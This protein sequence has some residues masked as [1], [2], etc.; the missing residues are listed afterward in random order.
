[1]GKRH[2]F[3]SKKIVSYLLRQLFCERGIEQAAQ[4]AEFIN[5]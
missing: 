3:K 5:K 2:Q 4:Q 1:M